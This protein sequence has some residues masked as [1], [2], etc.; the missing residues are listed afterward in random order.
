VEFV[1]DGEGTMGAATI[2]IRNIKDVE[3]IHAEAKSVLQVKTSR[4]STPRP[5][6]FCR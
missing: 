6:V 4:A 2:V 1:T 3:G 5:R